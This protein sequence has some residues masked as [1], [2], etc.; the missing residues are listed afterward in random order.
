MIRATFVT[1]PSRELCWDLEN[2]GGAYW[3]DGNMTSIITAIGWKWSDEKKVRT[4]LLRDDRLWETDDGDT[5]TKTEALTLFASELA[6]AT[7]VFGHN[8]RK[9]DLPMF[10]AHLQRAQLP[11]LPELR[12]TDTLK[13][14]PKR[15]G[16]AASLENLVSMYGIKGRKFKMSQHDW[17][18]ANELREEGRALA[19]KRVSSDVLLQERLRA[20]LLDLG[21]LREPK[22]WRP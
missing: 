12:T 16:M 4:L 6:S 10:N 5:M 7:L 20:K 9:H 2:M 8:I 14:I 3:F 1:R 19:R 15:A 21:I 22:V 17:E 11:V 13:D 18:I